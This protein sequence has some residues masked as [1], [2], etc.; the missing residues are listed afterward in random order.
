MHWFRH[1]CQ[2]GKASIIVTYGEWKIRASEKR[3]AAIL[4]FCR[5]NYSRADGV[6]KLAI[7][8]NFTDFNTKGFLDH[9]GDI[10]IEKK[11]GNAQKRTFCGGTGG[12]LGLCD[13]QS[14]SLLRASS[15]GLARRK[16]SYSATSIWLS[17]RP[18]ITEFDPTKSSSS[19]ARLP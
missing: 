3:R 5:D 17:I 19:G 4:E 9:F 12:G 13:Q 10:R 11:T 6:Y 16:R 18:T 8:P 14:G 7:H 2:H 1:T 15:S